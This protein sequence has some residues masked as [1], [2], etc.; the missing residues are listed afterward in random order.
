M[1]FKVTICGHAYLKVDLNSVKNKWPDA[2]IWDGRAMEVHRPHRHYLPH[3]PAFSLASHEG[4]A[5]G[6]A[7]VGMA[8]DCS[9]ASH[10][11]AVRCRVGECVGGEKWADDLAM[12]SP[13]PLQ[14]MRLLLLLLAPPQ[15]PAQGPILLSAQAT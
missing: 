5:R 15:N 13:G 14:E 4:L 3:G 12:A 7:G 2:H 11:P 9:V 8:G 6:Q 10:A 1:H